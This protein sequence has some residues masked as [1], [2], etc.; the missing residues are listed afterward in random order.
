MT[1]SG[2]QTVTW[3]VAGTTAAPVNAATVTIL[4]STNG[5]LSFP[6]VLAGNAPNNGACSVLLP[7]LTS[8]AARIKVQAVGN[9]FF[10]VSPAN[11]SI[12]APAPRPGGSS[13]CS[14]RT[15]WPGSPGLR[16]PVEPT[17]SNTSQR[18]LPPTGWAP[19]SCPDITATASTATATDSNGPAEQ[20]YYRI[21]AL[22]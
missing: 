15:A 18:W 10:A 17:A 22:P 5:G 3:N 19:T 16:S 7:P 14:S 13:R 12:V 1:W 20:R 8:S 21:V 4:L 11:F 2:A 6:I 9:I